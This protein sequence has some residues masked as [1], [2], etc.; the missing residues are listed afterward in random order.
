MA[1]ES[2]H[3]C[4]EWGPSQ[5]KGLNQR[6]ELGPAREAAESPGGFHVGS[7]A[8]SPVHSLLRIP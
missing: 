8:P 7:E 4:H 2:L 3:T 1:L 6:S 5:S